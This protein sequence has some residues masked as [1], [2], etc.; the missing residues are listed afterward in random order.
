[1]ASWRSAWCAR[2]AA[3]YLDCLATSANVIGNPTKPYAGL[4][5]PDPG[6]TLGD[7]QRWLPDWF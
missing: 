4:Y 2:R 6:P 7:V 1:M 5:G 3:F